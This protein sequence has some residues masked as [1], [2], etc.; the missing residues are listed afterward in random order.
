MFLSNAGD[1][2]SIDSTDFASGAADSIT[3]TNGTNTVIGGAAGDTISAGAGT[4]TILGDDGKA[5]FFA[6]GDLRLIESINLG[7]GG[8]DSITLSDGANSVIA[9]AGNDTISL[10][11]G[12]NFVLGD[13][14]RREV[15]T[16]GSGTPTGTTVISS[17]NGLVGGTDNITVGS[18]YNVVAGG[19]NVDTITV[20]GTTA[21]A[22]GIVMGDNGQMTLDNSGTLL[23]IESTAFAGGAGDTIN[24]T[25]GT[26][27][28]IGGAGADQITATTGRNTVLGDDGK[29]SFFA[30]GDL[31]LIETI[32]SGNGGN[33]TITLQNGLNVV[34]A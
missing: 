22:R 33:D 34:I 1:L 11:A 27:A 19:A 26:N 6:N 9:G 32:N 17:L 3:L 24:L 18:G 4:N 28:I 14:G 15:L 12:R 5:T 7:S 2:L 16:D 20:N 29:A 21:G 23:E 10:G 8:N 30:N 31:R 13:E 25:A